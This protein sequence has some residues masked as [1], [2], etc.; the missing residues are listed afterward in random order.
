MPDIDAVTIVLDVKFVVAIAALM[1]EGGV[2]VLYQ[3]QIK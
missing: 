3:L 2:E 1:I